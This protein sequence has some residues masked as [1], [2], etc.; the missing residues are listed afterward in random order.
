MHKKYHLSKLRAEQQIKLQIIIFKY[1]QLNSNYFFYT[2]TIIISN[3]CYN[4]IKKTSTNYLALDCLINLIKIIGTIW[5]IIAFKSLAYRFL[6]NFSEILL[7]C[8][9]LTKR[10]EDQKDK[11]IDLFLK[12]DEKIK[13]INKNYVNKKF[14][15]I[16]KNYNSII[17]CQK[18]FNQHFNKTMTPLN[19]VLLF[20][21]IYPSLII[22]DQNRTILIITFHSLNSVY[23]YLT[24][25]VL[26]FFNKNY[27]EA[28]S[29]IIDYFLNI[30]NK[31]M[32]NIALI[33]LSL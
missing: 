7:S 6:V 3:N 25:S 9:Y 29:I 12:N 20:T 10:L 21:I 19:S 15:I 1:A 17:D 8:K 4:S 16:L 18:K 27:L 33:F 2:F 11:I 22:Y 14:L 23:C 5:F 28:V 24:L 31:L 13:L 30:L 26:A 32:I